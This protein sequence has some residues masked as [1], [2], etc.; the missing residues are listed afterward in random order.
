MTLGKN[1]MLRQSNFLKSIKKKPLSMKRLAVHIV[2]DIQEHFV[3]FTWYKNRYSVKDK[4]VSNFNKSGFQIGVV[5]SYRV[6]VSLDCDA[7]YNADPDNQELVT[8]TGYYHFHTSVAG[9]TCCQATR[10]TQE[11]KPVFSSLLLM[12]T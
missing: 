8:V 2:E 10:H 4:D 3:E 7:I 11:R 9:F 5:T 6:Y 1:M 12:L